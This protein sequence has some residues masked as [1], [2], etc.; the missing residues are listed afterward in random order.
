[1]KAGEGV[2]EGTEE[3][4]SERNS[5]DCGHLKG[6]NEGVEVFWGELRGVGFD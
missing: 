5:K 2:Q 4:E 3:T 1:M 6:G